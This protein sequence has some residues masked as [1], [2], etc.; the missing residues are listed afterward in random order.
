MRTFDD[1]LASETVF[2][3]GDIKTMAIKLSNYLRLSRPEEIQASKS[4][5]LDLQVVLNRVLT[6]NA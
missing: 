6:E 3:S 4:E 1:F 5:L 2:S